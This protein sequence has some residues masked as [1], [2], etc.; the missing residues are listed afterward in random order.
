[1]LMMVTNGIQHP[2]HD[3]GAMVAASHGI[4]RAS[5][6]NKTEH[7]FLAIN[8]KCIVSGVSVKCQVHHVHIPFH[9][10]I[11]LGFDW[12]ELHPWNLTTLAMTPDNMKHLLVGHA[13][14]FTTWN[15]H[16]L[17]DA[18]RWKGWSD[19]AIKNDPLFKQR[20]T[21]R[22]KSW[23]EMKPAEQKQWKDYLIR[24]APKSLNDV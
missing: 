17:E 3:V 7:N 24:N 18:V 14:L 20:V 11:I 22:P 19:D 6:W 9:I 5:A 1:M 21:E 8:P 12:L 13:D 15:P 16:C 23:G 4:R 2:A 10:A